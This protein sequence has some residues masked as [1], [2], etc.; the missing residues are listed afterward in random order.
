M[1]VVVRQGRQDV[2]DGN[3][4]GRG[5]AMVGY[6][7]GGGT[8]AEMLVGRHGRSNDGVKMHSGRGHTCLW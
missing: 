4:K 2:G 8:V 6:W 5:M 1:P 3:R 7:N